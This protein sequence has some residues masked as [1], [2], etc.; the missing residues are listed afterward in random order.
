[1]NTQLT[2]KQIHFYRENGFLVNEDL[3]S[4][5]MLP[6]SFETF[7][8]NLP[9]ERNIHT[10]SQKEETPT[11]FTQFKRSPFE[12]VGITKCCNL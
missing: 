8:L 9:S 12:T 11:D 1:M 3:F 7:V 2:D 6:V 5:L 10:D 4:K